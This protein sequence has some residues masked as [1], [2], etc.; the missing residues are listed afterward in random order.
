M[1]IEVKRIQILARSEVSEEDF[2]RIYR[3]LKG[4]Q[5]PIKARRGKA[6]YK[7]GEIRNVAAGRD[8]MLAD[9]G[10]NVNFTLKLLG[11]PGEIVAEHLEWKL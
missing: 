8:A 5:L 2:D 1:V 7:V 3:Q 4:S 11:A 10:L 9:I 6:T